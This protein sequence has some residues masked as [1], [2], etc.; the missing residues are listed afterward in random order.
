MELRKGDNVA[1][2]RKI[3]L[4]LL[5]GTAGL[6][7]FVFASAALAQEAAPAPVGGDAAA[8]APKADE[9][10]VTGSRIARPDFT[11]NS[12]ITTVNQDLFQNSGTSAVETNLNKLPEFTPEKTPTLGGDIQATPTNTPGSAT[13]SLRGIGSNRNLVLIDGRRATPANASMAVD[14]NTIPS[15]AI[16]R[17]EIISGGASSTYG[18]DAVGGVVNFILKKNVKGLQLDGQYGISQR[19][20]AK[21][22]KVSGIMGTDFAEGRGNISMALE[23]NNRGKSLRIDR[24]WF[25]KQWNDPTIQGNYFFPIYS[26]IS[27]T[28]ANPAYQAALNNMFPNRPAGTNVSAT[29][30]LYFLGN[31]PFTFGGGSVANNSGVSNFPSN[32]IDGYITKKDEYGGLWQNFPDDY[33][34]LPLRRFNFYTRGTYEVNDWISVFAQGIFNKSHTDTVQQPGPIVGGWNVVIPRYANDPSYLPANLVT[35]LN[36]RTKTVTDPVTK[37]PTVVSAAAD[38]WSVTGY[39]PGLGNRRVY[40][41]VYTYNMVAGLNGKIPGTD[42]TWDITGSQGESVTNALTTGVA[43]LERLRAV[44]S[45]PNFGAGFSTKGNATGGGFGASSATCTTGL[46]PFTGATP[47]A[48]CIAAINADLKEQATMHQTIW[49]ANVQGKLITLWA[50]DLRASAGATYRRNQYTFLEDTLKT[51]GESFQDQALGIYPANNIRAKTS[52]KEAYGE[53][54]IPLLRDLPFIKL[55][56]LDAGIRYADSNIT[57]GSTTWKVEG[58]WEATDFLRFRAT[59]NKAQRA[60]NLGELY[61]FTQNFGL[62][63]G[64]DACSTG[65]PFSYSA[66][67][68]NA[69]GNAVKAL[70]KL[71][72]DK[73]NIPGQPANS[74]TFY[75]NGLAPSD[76][77]YQAPSA[78]STSTST[79]PGFAFPYFVGNPNLKPEDARTFTVGAVISSPFD[80]PLA[81]RLRLS[82]DFYS[83]SVKNAIGLQSGQTLQQLCLDK[84]FNPT[85]DPNTFYCN[86]FQRGTGGGIGAVQLAYTNTGAFK[87]KGLDAQVDWNIPLKETVG[88]PGNLGFNTVMNYLFTFKSSP[89]YSGVPTASQ[90]PFKEYAGTFAAP[91]SGLSANGQYRWKLFTTL[92]YSLEGARIGLQWQHLPS[93]ASGTTNT[94][95]KAYDVFQLS[96]S[97]ALTS[98]FT[99][100]AGVDNLFDKAPVS[101]NFNTVAVAPAL[102]GGTGA[103]I[104]TANYDAIGRR[105]YFGVNAKF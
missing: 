48:D 42:W 58:S 53:I 62:L 46:N 80:T 65:N 56:E 66:N 40:S 91:D 30:T 9:I 75:G 92:S 17:V 12:P 97:Y 77:L 10:V 11:S 47:S 51:S 24:P 6:S 87:T 104:N 78:G 73:T 21:E 96:G 98:T 52:S 23:T 69:N 14:I 43:S 7:A 82:L 5:A 36:L 34:N 32:L 84:A 95:Y 39:V 41:D 20:D 45:A 60:P 64:G 8:P 15:A 88:L 93:I 102:P 28:G 99:V 67:P 94:G 68:A 85:F 3:R 2:A 86:N 54:S 57:G 90:T 74:V 61:S 4:A 38:P 72:M 19:G 16:E 26:G 100:R 79:A 59:Y 29:G 33:V 81:R 1:V 25:K 31:T 35:L 50:G 13:V 101:G 103:G 27:Q 83:I 70:C 105:F 89:F 37:L 76:P 63:T 18:A 71:L 49:E 44:M 55:L 22:Y